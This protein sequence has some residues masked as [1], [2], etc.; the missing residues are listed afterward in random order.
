MIVLLDSNILIHYASPTDAAHPVVVK[1]L[2]ALQAVGFALR[3][4][5]QTLYEFW[6]VA[7]RPTTARGLGL[8]VAECDALISALEAV[9]PLLDDKPGLLS[10]WRKLVVAHDC[11]GKAAH[12][13]R[14]VAAMNAHGVVRVMTLN[15]AD[16][17]RYPGLIVLD[18]NAVAAGAPVP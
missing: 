7:T 18:P 4:V 9:F 16:F 5:P 12:D 3:I 15:T 6:V 8:S 14:I 1:A 11:K 13:A 10:E 17:T 2:T